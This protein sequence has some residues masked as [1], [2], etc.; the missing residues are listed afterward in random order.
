MEEMI[1][2]AYNKF[3]AWQAKKSARRWKCCRGNVIR[4]PWIPFFVILWYKRQR[5]ICSRNCD[6][7]RGEN[8][9]IQISVCRSATKGHY[10]CVTILRNNRQKAELEVM[11]LWNVDYCYMKSYSY[12]N[13]IKTLF[14]RI[15][16]VSWNH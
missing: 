15:Y 12:I 10:K 6:T 14:I 2:A 13:V 7:I 16:L 8:L 1:G 4:L 5:L 3:N 11:K 9:W